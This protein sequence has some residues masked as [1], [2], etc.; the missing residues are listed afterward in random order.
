VKNRKILIFLLILIIN[1]I[2]HVYVSFSKP[3]TLLNW[4]LT[5]DAFYYFKTAQ[6]ISE[7]IGVTF[8]GIAP[9]NGFHPLWM[10]ICVPVFALARFD[11]FLPLRVMIILLGVLNAISGYLLYRIFADNLSEEIGWIAAAFW[12]F[13]PA[14][15]GVTTKLGLESG[16]NALSIL[17]LIFNI[18]RL[19]DKSDDHT[20]KI[21]NYIGI[22]L[23]ASLCLLSRLDNIFIVLM[24]GV[25]LM[26]RSSSL[27]WSVLLDF[28]LII[29]AVVGAYYSRI[30]ETN[31]IFNFL[32]FFYL[33]AAFSLVVRPVTFYFLHLY[34]VSHI[35]DLKQAIL[36]SIAGATV[37]SLLIGLIFY[38][39][40][41][42]MHA[43]RGFSRS[44]LIIDWLLTMLFIV[45]IRVLRFIR[46]QRYGSEDE[47]ITIKNNWR[48]WL[49]AVT[50]YFVPV[51]T[52]L[53]GYMAI[54]KA[55]AGTS[56]PV[57]G[58]IKRWWGTLPNTVYGRP[59]TTLV[60]VI[61]GIFDPGVETG[62]FW[63]ITKP[64]NLMALWL[65]RIFGLASGN[66]SIA[67]SYMLV[68]V[69]VVVIAVVIA[70]LI[71]S[72]Q[73]FTR[74]ADRLGLIALASGCFIHV[75]SYKTTGYLSVKYW[76]WICEMIFLVIIFGLILG[77][78]LN[79]LKGKKTG[80]IIIKGFSFGIALLL[81]A[82]FGF[83]IVRDFPQKGTAIKQYDYMGEKD[84]IESQT[85]P[86]DVIG[87]TGGGLVG[88]FVPDRKIVNLDG[89]INS[90]D[91][92]ERLKSDQANDYLKE[93][94]VRY[95]YGEAPVL[96]DSDPYRWVFTD[97][98]RFK[99]MGPY[100]S[101]FDYCANSCK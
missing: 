27:R 101:L 97:H 33:L 75:I 52:M 22:S 96:L 63:L 55:Y 83:S 62:P 5:D 74:L 67:H 81:A 43:F 57:S 46:Y 41:D 15:H 48:H 95:I 66:N 12:M 94:G 28:C 21:K 35:K 50:G 45:P 18:A 16:I 53:V 8:D 72:R 19:Q 70:A 60:G 13:F 17:F 93:I 76:Y 38:L 2:P 4:Y 84:F 61:N 3:D 98:I 36:R 7:G 82:N 11:L 80:K 85:Q 1:L 88:Y 78:A 77:S 42:I 29:S 69:W 40:H 54:N 87:L 51:L 37:S 49:S 9:T 26:F 31:N 20:L 14:I 71:C 6:N 32:P 79:S 68:L 59:I 24:V 90:A 39:V 25:W 58:L 92:F 65:S 30:Q 100:F 47:D 86:G 91:Y 23:A 44:V 73:I 10:L 64:I 99:A 34:D 56:M 89:L